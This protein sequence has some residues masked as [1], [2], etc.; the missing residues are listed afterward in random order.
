MPCSTSANHRGA[1]SGAVRGH[2]LSRCRY[3]PGL[4]YTSPARMEMDDVLTERVEGEKR[5]TGA[6]EM[7]GR[8]NKLRRNAR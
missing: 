3:R 2:V 7:G 6:L 1:V 5:L 8:A 4:L